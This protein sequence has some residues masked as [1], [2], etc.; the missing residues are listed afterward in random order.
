MCAD[1]CAVQEVLN[2]VQEEHTRYRRL[3]DQLEESNVLYDTLC[4]DLDDQREELASLTYHP[5]PPSM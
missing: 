5:A 2:R 3:C 1:G 4:A